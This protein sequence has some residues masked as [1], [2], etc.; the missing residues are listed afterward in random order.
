[1]IHLPETSLIS[2]HRHAAATQPARLPRQ[3]LGH[4]L[5]H[6][7]HRDALHRLLLAPYRRFAPFLGVLDA[8]IVA[9][10]Q[11]PALVQLAGMV[12]LT[13]AA[14]WS[15]RRA[16]RLLVTVQELRADAEATGHPGQAATLA[17]ALERLA[18]HHLTQAQTERLH[19][20]R[21]DGPLATLRAA[22]VTVLVCVLGFVVPGLLVAIGVLS[23]LL[24]PDLRTLQQ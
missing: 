15:V 22:R 17:A 13:W 14:V 19:A 5:S 3:L 4:E 6:A 9:T 12:A 2:W 11:L 7:L 10:T 24:A 20:L 16:D 8:G 18:G 1:M 23:G 21:G